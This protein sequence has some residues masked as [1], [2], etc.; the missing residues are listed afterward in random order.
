MAFLD[1]IK[2]RQASQQQPVAE[3]S[4]QQKPQNAK[5]MYTQRDTQERAS[6]KPI[7]PEIKAQADRAAA[8]MN[9]ASQHLQSHSAPAAPQDGGSPAVQ[10]QKQN[11]QD[12]TQ[13]AL[14]PTDGTAG[15][16][17]VQEKEKAPEKPTQR[18]SQTI[19]R[20][21]PSWER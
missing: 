10:M 2:N 11:G 18:P 1:F 14:S 21:P 9:K 5:E 19:Q 13:G 8:T 16:T 15:K 3:N 7:T 6:A 20:R 17:A 12:K 4:Q